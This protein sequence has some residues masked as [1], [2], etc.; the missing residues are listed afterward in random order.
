MDTDREH[1]IAAAIADFV[2]GLSTGEPV[3][4]E[5]FCRQYPEL[6]PELSDE[7]ATILQIDS[8]LSGNAATEPSASAHHRK[9]IEQDLPERLSGNKVVGEIGA[10]GMGRVV[11][12]ID[13]RL[14]R[15]VAIKVLSSR[16]WSDQ[17]LRER[18]MQ[19]ARALAALQHPNIVGIYSL[20][21]SDQPP[22]F[23]MEYV[24]GVSL[25]EAARSMTLNQKVD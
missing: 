21:D 19:E 23:V 1:L 17:Q 25:T 3:D 16:Y 10:G 5:T 14:D 11:L 4:R 13:E 7:V 8:I 6:M 15:K 9:F 20:G 24:Q 12:G 2:D 22:H 18:F